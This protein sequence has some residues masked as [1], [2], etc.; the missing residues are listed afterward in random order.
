MYMDI[1]R[2]LAF[3]GLSAIGVF[4]IALFIPG[5]FGQQ[6]GFEE[7]TLGKIV[8]TYVVLGGVVPWVYLLEKTRKTVSKK[9]F[10][11]YFLS[12]WLMA[13]Y[14]LLKLKGKSGAN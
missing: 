1:E 13:P 5:A 10:A 9:Q 6:S 3:L 2:K 12:T 7:T 4:L 11:V 8:I 14:F